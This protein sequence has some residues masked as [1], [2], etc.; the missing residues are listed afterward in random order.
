MYLRTLER[1]ESF[2]MISDLLI[3]KAAFHSTS[4]FSTPMAQFGSFNGTSTPLLNGHAPSAE[5][6]STPVASTSNLTSSISQT[7][8]LIDEYSDYYAELAS[9][10]VSTSSCSLSAASLDS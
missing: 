9:H 4:H 8:T 1:E 6:Q 2:L 5:A 3:R 10:L 7:P